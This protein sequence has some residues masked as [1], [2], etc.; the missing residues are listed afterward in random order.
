MAHIKSFEIIIIGGSFAGLSAAMALGRALRRVLVIDNQNP[1]NKATPHSHNFITQDGKTPLE[2][3]TV[4]K[5]QVSVY[6]TVKFYDG[7]AIKAKQNQEGFEIIT[8]NN[9]AFTAKKL[10]FATGLKD[11][12]PNI[13]GFSE[14]WGKTVI[15]CP[16]CHG[17]EV[18][19]EATGILANGDMAFHYAQLITNWTKNL[20]IF[21]NGTSTLTNEQNQKIAKHNIKIIENKISHLQ[22][23]NGQLQAIIFKDESAFSV[24]AIYAKPHVEQH[25]NLPKLLGCELTEQNFIKV[26]TMQQT[27]IA[28]IYAC[29]DNASPFRAVSYAV[30]TGTIAGAAANNALINEAF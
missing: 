5:Q 9:D 11:I 2:I 10:I 18:K 16:Y 25:C 7:L 21:T 26:D 30:S 13:P 24:K 12:M 28:G 19:H 15:H 1:C 22:N 23:K 29:G 8:Q 27:T 14:C 6:K 17:Y 4:A 3:T 20:T